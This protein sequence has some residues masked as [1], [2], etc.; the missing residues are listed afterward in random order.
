VRRRQL[1]SSNNKYATK[2]KI[3]YIYSV[4]NNLLL[5]QYTI[6]PISLTFGQQCGYHTK[7]G[8]LQMPTRASRQTFGDNARHDPR[9]PSVFGAQQHLCKRSSALAVLTWPD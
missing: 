1:V 5:F 3:I 2:R 6:P 4:I 9:S 8:R 7:T